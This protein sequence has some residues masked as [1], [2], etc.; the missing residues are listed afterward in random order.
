[1]GITKKISPI[2]KTYSQD[3]HTLES[4]LAKYGYY[5]FPG[6]K[7][8]FLPFKEAG[9][10]RTGLDEKAPYLM[11]L[12]KE[13]REAEI[14]RIRADRK[15][16]EELTGFDLSP[17]SDYY[18]YG[19]NLPE[20]EKVT[21]VKIGTQDKFFN[22][23]EP[24]Q[25]ITWNWI[26]VHPAVAPSL[27]AV[28]RGEIHPDSVQYFIADDEAEIRNTFAIKK[29]LNQAISLNDDLTPTKRKQIARLMGLPVAGN[30]KDEQVYNLID[31]S[32]KE[33]EFISGEHKGINAVSLFLDLVG[34]KD[35][36]LRVKDLVKMAL[37][38]NI[39]RE[40]ANGRIYEGEN[41]V[42]SSVNALVDLLLKDENQ[43]DLFALEKKLRIQ[44]VE[45]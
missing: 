15:R 45:S 8:T 29:K 31:T 18:N 23:S 2:K 13:E 3:F 37:A 19:S 22:L 43:E 26:K 28:R 5:R 35:D 10:Y 27:D 21:P 32:L 14:E 38:N 40:R 41:E 16:L 33:G 44:V 20:D 42:A 30:A 4:S 36:R 6:T 11:K 17:T 9:R 7:R 39:Y 12:S 25:E 24:M 34:M 1:M